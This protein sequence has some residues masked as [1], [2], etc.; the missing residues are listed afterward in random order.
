MKLLM[1]IVD[2]SKKEELEALLNRLGV[3]G[4]TE[5]PRVIGV[6]TTGPR[7]GSRAF[8]KTSAVIFSILQP[9][10]FETL[11]KAIRE[12]CR[13]CGEKLKLVAWDVHEVIL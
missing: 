3:E 4:Y 8:P 6:G 12:F 9:Q 1:I 10:T 2:E 13:E 7:L 5:I 11:V